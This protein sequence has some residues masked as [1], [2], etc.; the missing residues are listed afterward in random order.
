M[1]LLFLSSTLGT[2]HILCKYLYK[3]NELATWYLIHSIGNFYI[4]YL[5]YEP[6]LKILNDP[7][8]ELF[9]PNKY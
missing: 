9:N 4:T 1:Q 6:I 3:L 5:C 7:L 8:Y 2:V